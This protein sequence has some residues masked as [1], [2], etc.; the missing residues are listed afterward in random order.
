[1][2]LP[3]YRLVDATKSNHIE[4]MIEAL[5][6]GASLDEHSAVD[7][8]TL[9]EVAQKSG[10]VEAATFLLE[11][12]TSPNVITRSGETLLHKASRQGDY[13]FVHILLQYG[14]DP[15]LKDRRQRRAIDVVRPKDGYVH[16]LLRKRSKLVQPELF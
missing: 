9:L 3:Q 5:N 13:G 6:A 16:D 12:G 15:E 10:A 11:R 14:A 1:M 4:A 7:R 8:L 2:I